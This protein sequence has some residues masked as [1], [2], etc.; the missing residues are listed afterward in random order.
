M[1][2]KLKIG[3]IIPSFRP[4]VGGAERQLEG[5]LKSLKPYDAK[6]TVFTRMAS[7][8]LK[9]EQS[10]NY[11]LYRLNSFIPKIGF[12]IS[13]FFNLI[14]FHKKFD[15][16]HCH[17]LSGQSSVVS[18]LIGAILRKP[19]ILKVT[20]SG[21]DAQIANLKKSFFGRF[22]LYLFKIGSSKFI[23]ITQDVKNELID[24]EVKKENIVEIPNG[25]SIFQQKKIKDLE[26]ISIITIGRLINRKRID[27]LIDLI[28]ELNKD[29]NITLNIAGSGPN[30]NK[31]RNQVQNLNISK[32]VNFL[33]QIEK[34][35]IEY[36]LNK[37]D[38]FVLPSESEGMSNALLEAMSA[39]LPSVVADIPANK[40]LILDGKTGKTFHDSS[41]LRNAIFDLCDNFKLRTSIGNSAQKLIKEKYS[42]NKIANDYYNLYMELLNEL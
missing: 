28:P 16:I 4:I 21:N 2:T 32:N 29:F 22:L 20:R 35:E 1:N 17:S 11:E 14:R 36:H 37:A 12:G 13:L 3:M 5:L 15:L 25:V 31:L 18:I 38:M 33:G 41:S 34:R 23:A 7:K 42:F 30:E 10:P 27:M 6:I 9:Y 24:L 26:S 39:G 19:V 40:S 8:S